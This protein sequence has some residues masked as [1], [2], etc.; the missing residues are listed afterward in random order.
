MLEVTLWQIGEHAI[1]ALKECTCFQDWLRNIPGTVHQTAQTCISQI[2]QESI[3]GIT[4]NPLMAFL[5]YFI[6][7]IYSRIIISSQQNDMTKYQRGT[8]NNILCSGNKINFNT[9]C[10]ASR[11]IRSKTIITNSS[12]FRTSNWFWSSFNSVATATTSA[13][14]CK[15]TTEYWSSSTYNKAI[16]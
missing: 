3:S 2:G 9:L 5:F 1:C 11:M 7:S 4:L 6:E 10:T 8:T 12:N 16:T 13:A 15:A 14:F